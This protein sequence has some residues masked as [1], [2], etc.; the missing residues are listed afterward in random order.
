MKKVGICITI[1]VLIMISFN[2]HVYAAGLLDR[3]FGGA[4]SFTQDPGGTPLPL[5]TSKIS[6]TNSTIYN[7][8]L[9]IG[10]VCSVIAIFVCGIMI[11][12][13]S[14][15]KKAEYKEK[16]MPIL[17]GSIVIFGAFTIWETVVNILQSSAL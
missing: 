2:S 4:S 5:T 11:M 14:I 1:I 16:L 9:P 8:L 10:I 7:V 12:T 17:I 6:E 13:A 3:I 15:E